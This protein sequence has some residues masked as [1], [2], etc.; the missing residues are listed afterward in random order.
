MIGRCR[1]HCPRLTTFSFSVEKVLI[2]D[3]GHIVEF[4]RPQTLLQ[5]ES[6]MF[7][8]LCQ[9][10]GR[11]EFAELRRMAAIAARDGKGVLSL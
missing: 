8:A 2:L 11:K 5:K 7:Y 10:T 3:N 4:D 6:S 9:A 1:Q